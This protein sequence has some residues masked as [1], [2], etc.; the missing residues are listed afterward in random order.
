MS[1]IPGALACIA[2]AVSVPAQVAQ[3]STPHAVDTVS[4]DST[5]I[6]PWKVGVLGAASVTAAAVAYGLILERGWWS[7]PNSD[8]HWEK[9]SNDFHYAHNLDKCGHFYFGTWLGEGF[10]DAYQWAGFSEFSSYAL[11]GL[12]ASTT[13]L[14]IELKDAYA[15][16]WGFSVWDVTSGTLGGFYPMARRY[17]PIPFAYVDIKYS[18]WVNHT[19]Y[20]DSPTGGPNMH[21]WVD[22][23]VNET[24]WASIKVHKALPEAAQPYW[25]AWLNLA[26]GVGIDGRTFSERNGAGGREYYV[27]PDWDLEG[28]FHPKSTLGKRA[29][30]YANMIKWPAPTVKVY[31]HRTIYWLFP[32]EATF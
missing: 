24:F 4:R 29:L 17:V 22:D 27:G 8:F 16:T 15:P 23:Y 11:A 20:Y 28:M 13:H 2:L 19:D 31:P 32:T 10:H 7:G 5:R 14:G 1:R 30:H 3:D 6:I 26:V 21:V 25:P 9:P 12:S 18:Y